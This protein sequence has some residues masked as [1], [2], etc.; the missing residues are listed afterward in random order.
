MGQVRSER[1]LH[2]PHGHQAAL[3]GM[4][5]ADLSTMAGSDH[6]N[7]RDTHYDG[8]SLDLDSSAYHVE[9]HA[10][11]SSQYTQPPAAGQAQT[12]TEGS[13]NQAHPHPEKRLVL[14]PPQLDE[15]RQKLFDVDGL[16][17]LTHEQ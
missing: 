6:G 12:A 1:D 17:I 14:D 3:H 4:E 11:G 13:A 9:S 10:N 16:I 2:G 8:T 5:E 15:W 7:D